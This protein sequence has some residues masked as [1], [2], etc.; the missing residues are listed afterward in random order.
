MDAYR[1]ELTG[2]RLG[3]TI[4]KT[5]AAFK[6]AHCV[7][8]HPEDGPVIIIAEEV[9][10]VPEDAELFADE[11]SAADAYWERKQHE[12]KEKIERLQDIAKQHGPSQEEPSL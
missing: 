8:M 9:F 2:E 1:S 3:W 6:P 12:A 4:H 11:D 7:L 5:P 10:E